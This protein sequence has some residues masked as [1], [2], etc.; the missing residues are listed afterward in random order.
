M[1]ILSTAASFLVI[2]VSSALAEEAKFDKDGKANIKMSVHIGNL[3]MR[4]KNLFVHFR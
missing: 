4:I 1:R 2:F 3:G